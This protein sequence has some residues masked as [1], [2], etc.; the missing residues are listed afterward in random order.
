MKTLCGEQHCLD[1]PQVPQALFGD[2]SFADAC[3]VLSLAVN[4]LATA[5]IGYKAWCAH[6]AILMLGA[7]AAVADS[8]YLC[9]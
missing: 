9:L 2:N 1:A 8:V 6:I 3:A 4:V 7:R 5:L